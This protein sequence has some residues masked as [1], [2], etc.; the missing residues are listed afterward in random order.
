M[1]ELKREKEIIGVETVGD[2]REALSE[3]GL[4]DAVPITD[5]MGEGLLLTLFRDLESGEL[6]VV[7]K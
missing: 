6:S 2:L 4:V 1:G 5:C 3:L 7:L